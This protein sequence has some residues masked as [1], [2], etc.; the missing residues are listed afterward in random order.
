LPSTYNITAHQGLLHEQHDPP[1]P[2]AVLGTAKGR[3]YAPALLLRKFSHALF[4]RTTNAYGCVMLHQFHFYVECSLPHTQIALWLDGDQLRAVVDHVL[5][6]EYTCHY[7]WRTR[8]ITALHHGTFYATRFVSP[9][10]LLF[11]FNPHESLILYRPPAG[12][13]QG[14]RGRLPQQLLLFKM[15]L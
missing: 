14:H 11:P 2:L 5:V 15:E 1:I 12:G 7:S 13:H 4:P 9:Q 8:R 10:G 6:A 3:E